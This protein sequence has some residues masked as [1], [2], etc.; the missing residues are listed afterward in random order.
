MGSVQSVI[1]LLAKACKRFLMCAVLSGSLSL[2]KSITF[3]KEGRGWKGGHS[4]SFGGA[5]PANAPPWRR[6][7][8]PSAGQLNLRKHVWRYYNNRADV[9]VEHSL[10][11][12]PA[13]LRSN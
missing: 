10:Q 12:R 7:D 13:L 11:L 5:R 9:C 4:N 8:Q 6:P 1:T 3:S 2:S